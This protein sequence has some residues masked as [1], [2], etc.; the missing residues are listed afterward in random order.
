MMFFLTLMDKL[1]I[2]NDPRAAPEAI[3]GKPKIED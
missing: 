2:G 3:I 1:N